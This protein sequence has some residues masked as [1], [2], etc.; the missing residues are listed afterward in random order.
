M[1]DISPAYQFLRR[2]GVA[3]GLEIFVNVI[4]P[5]VVYQLAEPRFGD[6]HALF[7]SMLP[8]LGWSL[9]EFFRSRRIDSLSLLV[10]GGIALSL[11]AFIGTGS[12]RFLQ[13]RENLVTGLIGLIF[14]GSAI[15]GQPLIYILARAIMRRGSAEDLKTSA[16]LDD[17]E[18]LR[19]SMMVMTLVW[20]FGLI[21][22]AGFASVLVFYV[23]IPDYLLLSP[24]IGYGMLGALALWTFWYSRERR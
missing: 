20:G 14:V 7:A 23:S 2:R 8:P 18:Q 24:F 22:Q 15:I 9:L 13:L 21:A 11:L 4:S 12:A 1:T 3:I 16:T 6:V 17:D 19:R 10:L 5:F